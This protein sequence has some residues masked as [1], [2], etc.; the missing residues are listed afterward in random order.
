MPQ[1]PELYTLFSIIVPIDIAP[2][3]SNQTAFK[4][5]GT[6]SKR[7][8]KARTDA[9]HCWVAAGRPTT[10]P[11]HWPVTV[12]AVVRRADALDEYNIPEACKRLIDAIFVDAA[13]PDD[14]PKYVRLGLPRQVIDPVYRKHPEVEFVVKSAAPFPVKLRGKVS[15][16][17]AALVLDSQAKEKKIIGSM[18]H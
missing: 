3:A 17:Y 12:E 15:A 6:K 2:L 8:N 5:H 16:D 11:G 1:P 9:W 14:Q 7:F 13:T 4:H 10:V 18:I